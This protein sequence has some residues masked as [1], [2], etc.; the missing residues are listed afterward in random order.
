M[1]RK[2]NFILY[3]LITSIIVLISCSGEKSDE[4]FYEIVTPSDKI[5]AFQDLKN[6]G[7]KK[8]REYNVSDLEGATEAWYGFWGEDEY[9]RKDYEIRFYSSHQNA[10]SLGENLAKEVTGKNAILELMKAF[11]LKLHIFYKKLLFWVNC[12]FCQYLLYLKFSFFFGTKQY[13]FFKLIKNFKRRMTN[14]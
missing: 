13:F 7:F 12:T 6:I 1:I 4:L 5:F 2:T 10:V 8:S 9:S 14:I 11:D 3:S